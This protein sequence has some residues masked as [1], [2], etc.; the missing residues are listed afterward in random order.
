MATTGTFLKHQ[1]NAKTLINTKL[2]MY[3]FHAQLIFIPCGLER[4]RCSLVGSELAY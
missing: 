4:S 3:T 1:M 2:Y